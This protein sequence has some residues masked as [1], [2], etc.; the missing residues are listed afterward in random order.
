MR[1]I[2]LLGCGGLRAIGL[3]LALATRPAVQA[4]AVP[5]KSPEPPLETPVPETLLIRDAVSMKTGRCCPNPQVKD[6]VRLKS[7]YLTIGL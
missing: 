4:I 2:L 3:A 6:M 7:A 1:K 5:R